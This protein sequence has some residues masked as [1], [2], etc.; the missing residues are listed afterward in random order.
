MWLS[1]PQPGPHQPSP[2][3]HLWRDGPPGLTF[4]QHP[5]HAHPFSSASPKVNSEHTGHQPPLGQDPS[6]LLLALSG[7]WEPQGGCGR[8][9]TQGRG[10]RQVEPRPECSYKLDPRWLTSNHQRPYRKRHHVCSATAHFH[11][12]C[13]PAW[14]R[15]MWAWQR[16]FRGLPALQCSHGGSPPGQVT[17]CVLRA[18]SRQ[19]CQAY[20]APGDPSDR[21]LFEGMLEVFVQRF[22]PHHVHGREL[23]LALEPVS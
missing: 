10:H 17:R 9:V 15:R 7:L 16:T 1:W 5:K 13:S 3:D 14:P 22:Q 19:F 23:P 6:W 4:L 18:P 12:V 20:L 8:T 21:S 2:G 11:R